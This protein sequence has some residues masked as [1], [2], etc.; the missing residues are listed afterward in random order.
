MVTTPVGAEGLGLVDGVSALVRSSPADLVEA[1]LALRAD[2]GLAARMAELAAERALDFS[3]DRVRAAVADG[4]L[5]L[6]GGAPRP[7]RTH[8]A[9]G[10]P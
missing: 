1:V 10:T 5:A 3:W 7:V 4:L 6:E 8:Q 9:D 2:P